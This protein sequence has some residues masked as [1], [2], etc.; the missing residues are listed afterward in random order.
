MS[1]YLTNMPSDIVNDYGLSKTLMTR[2][3]TIYMKHVFKNIFIYGNEDDLLEKLKN[4]N[5]SLFKYMEFCTNKLRGIYKISRNYKIDDVNKIVKQNRESFFKTFE[6]YEPLKPIVILDFDKTITN[7][8][9]HNIYKY[10]EK[11][12]L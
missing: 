10:L 7:K 4:L 8:K 6:I 1:E 5:M 9:F 3:E 12:E 2:R 11:K